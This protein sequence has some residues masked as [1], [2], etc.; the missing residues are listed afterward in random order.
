MGVR[1]LMSFIMTSL[2]S[3]A[4]H[5]NLSLLGKGSG[6]QIV[7]DGNA[8]VYYFCQYHLGV[9]SPIVI[10]Y[11][12]LS[13]EFDKWVKCL[14]SSVLPI[15]LF[16]GPTPLDKMPTRL[17]RI[18]QQWIDIKQYVFAV[19][20]WYELNSTMKTDIPSIDSCTSV[21]P[22][23]GMS[24]I[25]EILKLNACEYYFAEGEAD[26]SI[27]QLAAERSVYAILTNDTDFICYQKLGNNI[28]IIP[29]STFQ[30]TNEGELFCRVLWRPRI[31]AA[32]Q[33]SHEYFPYLAAIAGH[34]MS[35]PEV[36]NVIQE[37][38]FRR[39]KAKK[40]PQQSKN[41]S[42][43]SSSQKRTA[44][45]R[46]RDRTRAKNKACSTQSV[47]KN[48][49]SDDNP[50]QKNRDILPCAD[51]KHTLLNMKGSTTFIASGLNT[52]LAAAELIRKACYDIQSLSNEISS[53]MN[54]KQRN[55]LIICQL[56]SL[57]FD[58]EVSMVQQAVTY[59]CSDIF[60][61]VSPLTAT[62][63][64]TMPS[65]TTSSVDI[66]QQKQRNRIRN[67]FNAFTYAFE[68]Y[69]SDCVSVAVESVGSSVAFVSSRLCPDLDLVRARRVYI[70][71]PGNFSD[72]ECG[73]TYAIYSSLRKS[74]YH[75]ILGSI[76][77]CDSLSKTAPPPSSISV[78]LFNTNIVTELIDDSQ[79]HIIIDS[80]NLYY[81]FGQN[82]GDIDLL[83]C[84]LLSIPTSHWFTIKNI[85]NSHYF[86]PIIGILK[87]FQLT[88]FASKYPLL[89][90]A[91]LIMASMKSFYPIS[92]RKKYQE[93]GIL[94]FDI[95]QLWSLVEL[96]VLHHNY[97][98]DSI[99]FCYF[100]SGAS[101]NQ[102]SNFDVENSFYRCSSLDLEL[103]SFILEK[104]SN[105]I[106]RRNICSRIANDSR[107]FLTVSEVLELQREVDNDYFHGSKSLPSNESPIM[108][109]SETIFPLLLSSA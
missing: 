62:T 17:N 24:V 8:L 108:Q 39:L 106:S 38:L 48:I 98:I 70:G 13:F 28:G 69:N 68:M 54:G 47:E 57:L 90:P 59:L 71:R 52:V 64:R 75:L 16:D 93:K 37:R 2:S 53:E 12:H 84:D 99:I 26:P 21:P 55:F 77:A 5:I 49:I 7:I 83:L 88:G 60:P 107:S 4:D 42:K 18:R 92:L 6:I 22:L 31:A 19:N 27:V 91:F 61:L 66:S 11:D 94:K 43:N 40:Q 33:I 10:D 29:L 20:K 46:E 76:S 109:I 51:M 35:V 87:L 103:F 3:Y 96:T 100:T 81:K 85:P 56:I 102:C 50:D 34:D 32:L 101:H 15:F 41:I 89:V 95:I 9:T 65:T 86:L 67:I 78:T 73:V 72:I 45:E 25:L 79:Y 36:L 23:L 14:K 1:G 74:L 80:N 63:I 104:G 44:K 30:F 82:L 58:V 105:L 97:V